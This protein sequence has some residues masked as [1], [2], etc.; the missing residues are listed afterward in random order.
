MPLLRRTPA[1]DP[2]A[3]ARL[4]SVLRTAGGWLPPAVPEP[5]L[6]EPALPE[7]GLPVP[8]LPM[9]G[10]T[11][12]GLTVP[13]PGPPRLVR[14]RHAADAA[15]RRRP[16]SAMAGEEQR[17]GWSWPRR[18]I[19]AGPDVAVRSV[20]GRARDG[21]IGPSVHAQGGG[22]PVREPDEAGEDDSW[23]AGGGGDADRAA[24][25]TGGTD[26]RPPVVGVPSGPLGGGLLGRW[27]QGRF[28]PGRRGVGAMGL[29]ALVSA[30]VA[31]VVVVRS[32]PH[33]IVA[34]PVVAAGVPVP[35][36]PTAG[37]AASAGVA[38]G[39]AAT[40]GTAAGP[41]APPSVVVS[42]GGRVPRPGLL[43]LP[44]GSRVD[45]AV[46]A[47]GG[48]LPGAD[49]GALNLARRLVD[50]E[51]IQVGVPQSAVAPG[52]SGPA[53]LLDLNGATLQQLD[54]LPGIGPVLAQKVL[55]WRTE[56]GRFGSVDQL[57]EVPGIGES[58]YAELKGK[59]GV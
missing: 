37:G 14:R 19:A 16:G 51:Q 10:A 23:D 39:S 3:V 21:G 28:D 8:G 55:D 12:A 54:A 26:L 32:R 56:H 52:A 1:A 2:Q 11:V 30:L 18:R 38:T 7:P 22:T 33:E 44:A 41:S 42:V 40:V 53:A 48:A 46:R 29:V 35:G 36:R 15:R 9:S 58:K 31:G 50:G 34:P 5:G 24:G 45:D 6:P 43:R 49:L 20:S 27:R 4:A 17:G 25:A 47:A 13:V 59:V 57:R